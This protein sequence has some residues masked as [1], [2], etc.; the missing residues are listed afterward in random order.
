MN[1]NQGRNKAEITLTTTRNKNMKTMTIKKLMGIVVIAA[2]LR[3][4]GE[5]CIYRHVHR[6]WFL[7]V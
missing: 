3:P 5:S 4:D 2:L 7:L 1:E 6:R